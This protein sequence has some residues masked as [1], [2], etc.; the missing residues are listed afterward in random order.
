MTA[1]PCF[2]RGLDRP[3]DRLARD[4]LAVAGMRIPD[5]DRA[6]VRDDLRLLVGLQRAGLEIPDIGDQHADAMAVMAAQ[7]GL[8]Q[9]VGDDGGLR[10]RAAAGRDDLV[11]ERKQSRVVDLHAVSLVVFLI[12]QL[13]KKAGLIPTPS[14]PRRP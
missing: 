10:R 8:D 12:C 5:R 4:H 9:M 7:I 13:R 2:A 1:T 14:A 11:G 3:L 6:G